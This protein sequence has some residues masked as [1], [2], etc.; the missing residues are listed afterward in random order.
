MEEVGIST[1]APFVD[2]LPCR[3]ALL[4]LEVSLSPFGESQEETV[5]SSAWQPLPPI[6]F[7]LRDA[8]AS[9]NVD[10]NP[11]PPS[12]LTAARAALAASDAFKGPLLVKTTEKS[13]A[14]RHVGKLRRKGQY[15][16]SWGYS[17][18]PPLATPRAPAD[19]PKS[20]PKVLASDATRNKKGHLVASQAAGDAIFASLEESQSAPELLPP[21]TKALGQKE[22]RGT[23]TS[24]ARAMLAHTRRAATSYGSKPTTE[25]L[26]PLPG[27]TLGAAWCGA[28][29]LSSPD[30]PR[31]VKDWAAKGLEFTDGGLGI[32]DRFGLEHR[33]LARR[34]P[35]PV[36]EQQKFGSVSLW[37]QNV[38]QPTQQAEGRHH[39]AQACTLGV[40]REVY[41]PSS[42]QPGPGTYD[43]P[44]FVD[45][46]IR[47][48]SKRPK[49]VAPGPAVPVPQP[50]RHE[51]PF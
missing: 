16:L 22:I 25:E 21:P 13:R 8:I 36:Y 30:I 10:L 4:M 12:P 19:R 35:G 14:I 49:G 37:R 17:E 34:S 20:A 7:P 9:L 2:A 38:S 11:A 44:G 15:R 41:K 6:R 50:L 27:Q 18:E 24:D 1:G 31:P 23:W 46:L 51:L 39:S 5:S 43:L 32:G 33:Q 48:G 42:R 47:K 45:D 29:L 28:A 3:P 26:V 40:R